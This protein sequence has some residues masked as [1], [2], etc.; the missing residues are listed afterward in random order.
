MP[1]IYSAIARGTVILA[2]HA[3]ITGTYTTI[4]KRILET[5][6]ASSDSQKTYLFES[7]VFV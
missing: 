7:Y 1:I 2:E 5:T 6:P 3:T 4:I